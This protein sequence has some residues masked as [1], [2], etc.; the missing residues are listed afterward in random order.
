[1]SDSNSGQPDMQ[2]LFGKMQQF[3]EKMEKMQEDLGAE[4]V[5]AESGAGMIKVVANGRKEVLSIVIES[6]FDYGD[7]LTMLQD[8]LT[9]A[10][11]AALSKAE[12]RMQ[13]KMQ[14]SMGQVA[15]GMMPNLFGK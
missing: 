12:E 11:N 7:D 4:T 8:L 10:V 6:G 15:G 9:A 5:E 3:Q 2:A 13:E 14:S 1:M